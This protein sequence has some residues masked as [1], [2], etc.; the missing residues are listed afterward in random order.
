MKIDELLTEVEAGGF[1]K[2]LDAFAR[3]LQQKLGAD[4]ATVTYKSS[5]FFG[6]FLDVKPVENSAAARAAVRKE[7]RAFIKAY[8]GM[9]MLGMSIHYANMDDGLR[10]F[11]QKTLGESSRTK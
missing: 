11:L 5:A 9:H 7:V 8:A 4:L 3:K 2:Y 6:E 10:L 1:K